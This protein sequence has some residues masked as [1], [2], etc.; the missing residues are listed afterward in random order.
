MACRLLLLKL[1]TSTLWLYCAHHSAAMLCHLLRDCE[2]AQVPRAF[3]VLHKFHR[4]WPVSSSV[5]LT[6]NYHSWQYL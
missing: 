6:K 2:V 5:A 4:H 3:K 1:L